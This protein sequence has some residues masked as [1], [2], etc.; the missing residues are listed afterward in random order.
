VQ[1]LA[2]GKMDVGLSEMFALIAC[3]ARLACQFSHLH[4]ANCKTMRHGGTL[5]EPN[6]HYDSSSTQLFFITRYGPE[7]LTG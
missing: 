2:S 5:P 7:P 6:T 1:I 4:P 3:S